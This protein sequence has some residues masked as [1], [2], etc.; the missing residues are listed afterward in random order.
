LTDGPIGVS[1][2][3]V[4]EHARAFHESDVATSAGH[5]MAERLCDMGFPDS[6]GSV[7]DDRFAGFEPAQCGQV[8]Q[9]RGGQFRADGE[10]EVLEG[11]VLL[12]AG[13]AYSPCQRRGLAA[14][15]LVFQS[16]CRNSRWPS[17]RS[18]VWARRASRVSSIPVSLRVLSAARRLGS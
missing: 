3:E 2:G 17:F 16:T 8:A 6:D 14:G 12:E 13:T 4:G 7:E 5:L 10:V 18:R 15:D 1:T 9:R 11:A